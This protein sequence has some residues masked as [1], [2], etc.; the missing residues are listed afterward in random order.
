MYMNLIHEKIYNLKVYMH[1]KLCMH[2][3]FDF[4]INPFKYKCETCQVLYICRNPNL[5]KCGREAQHLEK[6]GI[7]SPPGLPNVQSSTTGLKRPRIG[8]FLVSLE[9]S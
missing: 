4:I 2:E 5:A 1:P 3:Y 6:L 8:V 9:R 7:W